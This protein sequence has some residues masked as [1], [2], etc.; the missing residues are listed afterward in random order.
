MASAWLFYAVVVFVLMLLSAFFSGSETAVMAVNRMRLLHLS[1]TDRRAQRINKILER[2]EKLIGTLLLCNNLVNVGLSALGTALA[3]ALVGERGILYAT[4]VITLVLLV[5]GEITPK[6][7]AAYH[8]DRIALTISPILAFCIRLLYPVVHFL[9]VLSNAL[10]RL[11]HLQHAS[12]VQEFSAEEIESL[13]AASGVETGLA[14]DKQDM[15]LGVLMLERLTVGDIMTPIRD[16]VSFPDDASYDQVLEVVR[17]TEFSR[18]PVYHQVAREIIGFIHVRDLFQ[19]S[20][21]RPDFMASILRQPHFIPEFRSVRQQF[22]DF[23]KTRSHLSLVV[24]EYGNVIGLLSLEDV[25]EE[26][27]GEIEDEHDKRERA[28]ESL[29]DGS[30]LIKGRTLIRDLN[31][32][33]RLTL[34]EGEVRTIAGLVLKELGRVPRPGDAVVIGAHRLIVLGIK[35]K[36]IVRLQ[37]RVESGGN[38]AE[39]PG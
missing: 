24:D 7:I 34:P 22:M 29:A 26:I 28:V 25:L 16:V 10:I 32:W 27:V 2:P 31:R 15:L 3:L 14:K 4:V 17:K 11:L 39:A 8:S 9:S 30:Y 1:K 5:F 19:S 13:I 20:P 37:L 35:G 21:D 36:S 38:G 18:Y 12:Q 6:T 33:L 23:Q